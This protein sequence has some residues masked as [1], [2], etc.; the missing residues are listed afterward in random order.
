MKWRRPAFLRLP[1]RHGVAEDVAGREVDQAVLA[2]Q[3]LAERALAG[4]G[5]PSDEHLQR[6]ETTEEVELIV[7]H[8][9]RVLVDALGALPFEAI[10]EYG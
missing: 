7:E 8:R 2:R 6:E 4:A 9:H 5:R 3:N 1:A 10:L